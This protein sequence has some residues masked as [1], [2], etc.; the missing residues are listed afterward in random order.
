M[1]KS[2]A[3]RISID[4]PIVLRGLLHLDAL[5]GSLSFGRGKDP[6]DVPLEKWGEMWCGSAAIL[7][8][9]PFGFVLTSQARL[10]H[11]VAE[12]VPAGIFDHLKPAQR[13]I[14]NMHLMKNEISFWPLYEGVK[15]VWFTGHG[16]EEATVELLSD[17]RNLG[18]MGRTGY[19]RI[20]EI[21]VLPINENQL[22]GLLSSAGGPMRT[23]PVNRWD[24]LGRGRPDGAIISLQRY[25]A[26]YWS[27][28]EV[29]CISPIQVEL[30]GT[31][32][33]INEIVGGH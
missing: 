3:V 19:G 9:G 25:K 23:I 17:A 2:F 12:N 26:P 14:D 15:A 10:K 31:F 13:K 22:S 20:V 28:S 30:S 4:T 1:M 32:A 24:E 29:P 5:L 7:E 16:D 11:I 21:E 33:D 18:A 6:L 8:T 27:G